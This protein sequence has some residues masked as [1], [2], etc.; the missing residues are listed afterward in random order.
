MEN[1]VSN[2]V[3][4]FETVMAVFIGL[5]TLVGALVAWRSSVA[6]LLAG[7]AHF[8]TAQAEHN[9]EHTRTNNDIILFRHYRAY[10]EFTEQQLLEQQAI[11]LEDPAA[12]LTAQNLATT[13][14]LFFPRR[15]LNRDGSYAVSRQ[16]GEAWAQAEQVL[17]LDPSVHIAE[18]A[19]HAQKVKRLVQ[20]FVV[21]SVTLIFYTL[22]EGVHPQRQKLRYSLATIGTVLLV[23]TTV[24]IIFV[25]RA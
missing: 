18:A 2:T 12:Q 9:V 22:A 10:T 7:D 16:L 20:I 17:D 11:L 4:R 6:G 8:A 1:T 24:A 21:L 19:V 14:Q 5:V 25:E 23:L 3:D 15:Y 13:N